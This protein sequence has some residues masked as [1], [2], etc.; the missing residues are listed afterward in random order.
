MVVV[1]GFEKMALVSEATD[2]ILV[3]KVQASN[4]PTCDLFKMRV[5]LS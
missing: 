4:L 2:E 1:E 5:E 3:G